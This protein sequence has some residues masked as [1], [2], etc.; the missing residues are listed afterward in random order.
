M[1]RFRTFLLLSVLSFAFHTAV[2][3]PTL[4]VIGDSYVANH[5]RPQS[6]SWHYLAAQ[7]QGWNYRNYGRN[8]GSIAW[9]RSNRGFG[10]AIVNRCLEMTDTADIVLVIAG[11]NDAEMARDNR[12]SL[13]MLA[14]SLDLLCRRLRDKY[15]K[16]AIGFVTPWHV[17]RPGFEPVIKTIHR[18]CRRWRIPVLDTRK[19]PVRVEDEAFRRQYFQAPDDHAHLN[20]QGHLLA[21]PWGEA[22]LKELAKKS[23][24]S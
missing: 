1:N 9:D 17:N 15:P 20:A 12:D 8:G 19:S 23:S 4:V 2:A 6:E 22:F 13:K 16:A 11:H 21:L 18:V 14:D 10:R 24:F 3:Q 5:R 7:R